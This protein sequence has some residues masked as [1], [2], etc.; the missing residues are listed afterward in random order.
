MPGAAAPC[1]VHTLQARPG[2]RIR[3]APGRGIRAQ[4]IPGCRRIPGDGLLITTEA[5]P[6]VPALDMDGSLGAHGTG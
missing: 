2:I 3:T 4:V 1:G 6:I 5:G